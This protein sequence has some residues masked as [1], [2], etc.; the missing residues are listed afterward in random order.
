MPQPLPVPYHPQKADGYCLAACAQMVLH[1]WGIVTNQEQLAQQLGVEPGVGVPAGG[2]HHLVE[3]KG[4]GDIDVKHKDRAAQLW[5]ENAAVLTGTGWL[6]RKVLQKGFEE[7]R[8]DD[9]EDLIALEPARL[10][11]NGEH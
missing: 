3:T 8:P 6:Y 10:L 7:L 1:Y 9:F 5:C 11:K 4:R 2:V